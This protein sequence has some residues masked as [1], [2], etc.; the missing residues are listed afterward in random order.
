MEKIYDW[1]SGN[2][3]LLP[4]DNDFERGF[5]TALF[6]TGLVLLLIIVLC[7]IIRLCFR[8]PAI[9]GVTL[10]REDGDIF[11]SRNALASAVYHLEHDF[12]GVEILKVVLD[13][14][15]QGDL[16][17]AVSMSYDE[18][19][20]SFETTAKAFK[21]RIFRELHGTFGIDT[22]KTVALSLVRLPNSRRSGGDDGSINDAFVAG[23]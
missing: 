17:L 9:P 5:Y 21:A 8:K 13:N 20:G 12:P 18:K 14:G 2:L 3:W 15:R 7:L 4:G 19:Q 6:L 22:V 11:I 10:E 1:V 16:E 23:I